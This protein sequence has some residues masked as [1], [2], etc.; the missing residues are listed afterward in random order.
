M[1][2][3]NEDQM[4]VSS[5]QTIVQKA[6]SHNHYQRQPPRYVY[7]S[8]QK[9]RYMPTTNERHW[10]TEMPKGTTTIHHVPNVPSTPPSSSESKSTPPPPPRQSPQSPTL[11]APQQQQSTESPTPRTPIPTCTDQLSIRPIKRKLTFLTQHGT[12]TPP[13]DPSTPEPNIRRKKPKYSDPSQSRTSNSILSTTSTIDFFSLSVP[14]PNINLQTP[15]EDHFSNPNIDTP[16]SHY[17]DPLNPNTPQSTKTYPDFDPYSSSSSQ[18]RSPPPPPQE[19]YIPTQSTPELPNIHLQSTIPTTKRNVATPTI[20]YNGTINILPVD[21]YHCNPNI[22]N[23]DSDHQHTPN[24]NRNTPIP[25]SLI[26]PPT[27]PTFSYDAKPHLLD[28]LEGPKGFSSLQYK[29]QVLCEVC[30][31]VIPTFQ[32]EPHI[33]GKRHRKKLR[34]QNHPPPNL[35]ITKECQV[36]GWKTNE[37]DFK[38]TYIKHFT[39]KKHVRMLSWLKAFEKPKDRGF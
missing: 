29:K 5:T 27:P 39:F 16:K 37:K 26:P 2:N 11:H 4:S 35:K 9:K 3:L 17:Q 28:L 22:T 15:S 1:L 32:W 31:V 19:Y 8:P 36:C 14:N 24:P 34:R 30:M 13:S 7:P 21:D 25:L 6:H 23:A 12:A 18:S 33:L 38:D 20:T 10:W